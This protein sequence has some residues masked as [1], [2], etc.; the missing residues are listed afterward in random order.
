MPPAPPSPRLFGSRSCDVLVLGAGLAGMRAAWAAKAADPRL[1]VTL[2][3][4]RRVPS[5][6]SFANR[7]DALGMQAPLEHEADAFVA[8]ALRLAP[9][10]LIRPEL[11]RALAADAQARLAELLDLSL[12]FRREP[13]G[14]LS[15][16][17]GCF[18]PHPRAV[19][20]DKLGQAHAAVLARLLGLGV[21]LLCGF[22][23][24]E[25][26]KE[27]EGVRGARLAALR[28]G[29]GFELRARTIVAAL[30]GPAP[31]F[32]RRLCGPG[33]SGL[34]C[35]LLAQAGARL[36]NTRFV[37]FFWLRARDWSFVNPGGLPWPETMTQLAEARRSHCPVGYGLPDTALDLELL[38]RRDAQ[39][40]LR[41][42]GQE[43]LI[44]A[45]HAGNGG[46][47]I[48]AQ[49]RT[50]VARLYACGECA[51][52]MHGANRLGG[53]MVLSALV[54]GARAGAA[55]AQ[56]AAGLEAGQ[57]LA[58]PCIEESLSDGG[59][60]FPA[61]VRRLRRGMDKNALPG[62]LPAPAFVRWLRRAAQDGPQR[63]RLLALSA[64]AV[65]DGIEQE[66]G[67]RRQPD[68]AVHSD[69]TS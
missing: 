22:E 51:G 41:L 30:G 5:G 27:G 18:S 64:L 21:E 15:R 67:A 62:A 57:A 13:D 47:L 58:A 65:L 68:G 60:A 37:Q 36:V 43:P 16:F 20:F 24:V 42:P 3:S 61:F 17:P 4:P 46:A 55:A 49:G 19:V 32:A 35:G 53:G 23:A 50:S 12:C 69:G 56:E 9:P 34:S 66:K 33:G 40:L 25:L 10:G 54:F 2:V 44:L 28:G 45:A 38:A 7:N 29:E 11:V 1:R 63:Q 39:G 26:L 48:D 14:G 59:R 31:L 52:G 6:S 8:E